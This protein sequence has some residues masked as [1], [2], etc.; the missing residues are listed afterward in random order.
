MTFERELAKAKPL[1]A[2]TPKPG[3]TPGL[4]NAQRLKSNEGIRRRD[5]HSLAKPRIVMASVEEA[6]GRVA[7]NVG[8]QF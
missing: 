8:D 4:K 3:C 2:L 5:H 6:I 7:G 1:A